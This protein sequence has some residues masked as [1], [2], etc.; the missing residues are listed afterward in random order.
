MKM[1]LSV[2]GKMFTGFG[3]MLILLLALGFTGYINIQ[4]VNDAY[5]QM[6][7]NRPPK[8]NMLKEITLTV[9]QQGAQMRT[10]MLLRD[11]ST[12]QKMDEL[13]KSAAENIQKLDPLFKLKEHKDALAEVKKANQEYVAIRTETVTL[14]KNNKHDQALSNMSSKVVP[15]DTKLVALIDD[16]V[17]DQEKRMADETAAAI[18]QVN[19]TKNSLNVISVIAVLVGAF[20]SWFISTMIAR[21][22]G[23]LANAARF[24]AAGDL[25]QKDLQVKNRDEFGDLVASFNTMKN[26][27]FALISGIN[28]SALQ[29]ASSAEELNASA[30]EVSKSAA[31]VTYRVQG[32]TQNAV[33]T[34]EAGQEFSRAM[35]ESTIGIQRIVESVQIV[36]ETS[37]DTLKATEEGNNAVEA[38]VSQ[39]TTIKRSVDQSVELAEKLKKQSEEIGA[40]T[41]AI[42]EIT[43]QTNLLALNAAIEAAR[44]GEHGRGFAIVA[45][46]VRKLAEQ[47]KESANQITELIALI[48]QDT[49]SVTKA[50]KSGALEVESGVKLMDF[51][52]QSFQSIRTSI[53]TVTG[54]VQEISASSEQ[55]SASTEQVNASVDQ[56]SSMFDETSRGTQVVRAASEEQLATIEEITAVSDSLSKMA[57][58]LQDMLN[59]FKI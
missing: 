4:K 14:E 19:T 46:E 15:A 45:D 36:S 20:I 18:A 54:Q 43:E 34:A 27:L 31:D 59:Q 37:A 57:V 44:A 30:E 49:V 29:V 2:R 56:I 6:L 32:M 41:N 7:E 58:E 10:Y 17:K 9:T 51:V 52:G 21:P 53:Q 47:S 22:V 5:I 12:L 50:M 55:M 3:A 38:A 24:I 16:M 40:I 1:K 11:E 23:L 26:N 8:I 42:M 35:E 48:Q 33:T 25:T 28:G 39:M 13:T